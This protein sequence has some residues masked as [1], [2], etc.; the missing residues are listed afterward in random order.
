MTAFQTAQPSRSAS[1]D[2][3]PAADFKSISPLIMGFVTIEFKKQYLIPLAH[4][5]LQS[6]CCNKAI[7]II[8][9][10]ERNL[11]PPIELILL[12]ANLP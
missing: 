10:I 6:K 9:S 5:P 8:L 3:Y 11:L 12:A 4:N 1:A 2:C 7:A